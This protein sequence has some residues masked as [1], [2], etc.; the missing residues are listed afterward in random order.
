MEQTK[1]RTCNTCKQSD[2]VTFMYHGI[3]PNTK[4]KIVPL[5]SEGSTLPKFYNSPLP[6]YEELWHNVK[7]AHTNINIEECK[8]IQD[9]ARQRLNFIYQ[10]EATEALEKM[11]K[12][13]EEKCS[14][15]NM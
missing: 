12:E 3:C 6:S 14:D 9:Y 11:V 15:K 7:L 2:C 8:T 1:G 13:Y 5:V 4:N 10:K